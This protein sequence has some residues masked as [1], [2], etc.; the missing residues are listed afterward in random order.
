M[1]IADGVLVFFPA[2][3]LVIVPILLDALLDQCPIL[4]GKAFIVSQIV[5]ILVGGQIVA[6]GVAASGK[7]FV[8][9]LVEIRLDLL[10]GSDTRQTA[11]PQRRLGLITRRI[12]K[13]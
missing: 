1:G 8:I 12:L 3:R 6:K 7:G 5:A 2:S 9:V 13:P 10:I 11:C 4:G